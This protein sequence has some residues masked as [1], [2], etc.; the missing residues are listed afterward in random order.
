MKF[1]KTLKDLYAKGWQIHDIVVAKEKHEVRNFLTGREAY[2]LK[3][4]KYQ[5]TNVNNNGNIDIKEISEWK[6]YKNL[7]RKYF[8]TEKEYE[9]DLKTIEIK[10][11]INKYN[12]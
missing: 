10:K 1:L 6:F 9:E 4:K 12:L 5:I 2:I 8:I 3:N 11:D 7:P